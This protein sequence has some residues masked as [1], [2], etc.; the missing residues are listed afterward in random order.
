MTNSLA[1]FRP[2]DAPRDG[3]VIR[4]YFV[5]TVEAGA[6][7]HAVSWDSA[8]STWANLLGEPLP[9]HLRLEAWGPN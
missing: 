4:G 6:G 7:F 2:E 8:R 9:A 1:P 3:T 5:H